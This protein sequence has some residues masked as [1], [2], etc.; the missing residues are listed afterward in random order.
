MCVDGFARS[1]G[2]GGDIE[3]T[4]VTGLVAGASLGRGMRL[5]S[6]PRPVGV[7]DL[8]KTLC[9][10]LS[11]S[12]SAFS[13]C[14]ISSVPPS[15]SESSTS[16]LVSVGNNRALSEVVGLDVAFPFMLLERYCRFFAGEVESAREI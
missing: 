2:L 9:W 1:R 15:S 10:V 13:S 12:R 14:K 11:S 8:L 5:V 3:T 16:S 6:P 7:T 4:P